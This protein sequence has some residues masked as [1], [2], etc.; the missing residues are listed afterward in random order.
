MSQVLAPAPPWEPQVELRMP[1]LPGPAPASIA[2]WG[3]SQLIENNLSFA[4]ACFL[5]P[6]FK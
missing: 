5:S 6:P 4:L 3:E 2:I 1:V